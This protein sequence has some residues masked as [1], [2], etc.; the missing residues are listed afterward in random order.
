MDFF[1]IIET[2]MKRKYGDRSGWK[3]IIERKY[4]QTYLD[5]EQFIGYITLLK[6][7]KYLIR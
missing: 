1:D 7:E 3:R 4:A 6:S 2:M 5:T